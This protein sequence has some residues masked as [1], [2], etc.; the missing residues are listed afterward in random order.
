ME[1]FKIV[2]K[3]LKMHLK[4]SLKKN[5][6]LILSQLSLKLQLPILVKYK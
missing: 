3:V 6:I 1:I 4:N 5:G 2:L